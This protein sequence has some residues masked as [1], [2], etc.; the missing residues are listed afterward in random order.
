MA[1]HPRG[2]GARL[3]AVPAVVDFGGYL[4]SGAGTRE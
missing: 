1:R 2:T 4:S 3:I